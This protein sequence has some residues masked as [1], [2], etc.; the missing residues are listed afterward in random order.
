[1]GG[2]ARGVREGRLSVAARTV[3]P[4]RSI[5]LAVGGPFRCLPRVEVVGYARAFT[6]SVLAAYLFVLLWL[7]LFKFSA[8]PLSVI[9]S[10]QARSLNLIPFADSSLSD[11]RD[12]FLAFFVL[13]LLLGIN[14]RSRGFLRKVALVTLLSLAVEGLQYALAIGAADITDVLMNSL[15]GMAGLALTD[16]AHKY[17]GHGNAARI[18]DLVVTAFV[19]A[20]LLAFL[21]L[22]TFVFQVRY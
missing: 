13:G 10:Y 15:G 11:M 19:A 7:V 4:T 9:A 5:L 18:L 16:L 6:R 21:W 20:L 12:N 3:D 17:L 2:A 14:D 8:D 22:R 1:M